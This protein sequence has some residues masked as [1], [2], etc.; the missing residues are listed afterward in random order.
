MFQEAVATYDRLLVEM[1]E[2]SRMP[3]RALFRKAEV[4]QFG[5][6]RLSDAAGTYERL[7]VEFPNSVL[8]N[9]ARQRIRFLRGETL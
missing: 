7:L 4:Q 5:L 8:A 6:Q 2:Q 3:D 1:R 9:A